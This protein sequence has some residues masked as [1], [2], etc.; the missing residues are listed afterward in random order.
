M[1]QV[2]LRLATLK[3]SHMQFRSVSR[4]N[5]L[6]KFS[7]M[8]TLQKCS[9]VSGSLIYDLFVMIKKLD[10]CFIVLVFCVFMWRTCNQLTVKAEKTS[11]HPYVSDSVEHLQLFHCFV[12]AWLQL[13][14]DRIAIRWYCLLLLLLF[15]YVLSKRATRN[16]WHKCCEMCFRCTVYNFIQSTWLDQEISSCCLIYFWIK[17]EIVKQLPERKKRVMSYSS[18]LL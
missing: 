6:H 12:A 5:L 2:V 16:S 13:A 11:S 15:L 7:F 1:V 14:C 17:S 4:V 18:S 3:N 10:S 8:G 9:G